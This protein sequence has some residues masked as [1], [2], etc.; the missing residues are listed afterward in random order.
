MM[1]KR[2][3]SLSGAAAL[4][5]L[6]SACCAPAAMAAQAETAL[7][8]ESAVSEDTTREDDVLRI[9]Q[10]GMFS[11]GG[12]VT[13]PV[14]G[15]YDET[16]N[17]QDPTRAGNTMHVDHA[18]VFYQIPENDNGNPIVFLHGAGQSRM[19]WMTT[20]DGREGWS[21][22]FLK[23]WHSVFLVDQPRRGEAGQTAEGPVD[24]QA[25]DQAWYTLQD[26]A[27]RSGTL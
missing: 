24:T 5:L 8:T 11:A 22:I 6:L 25:G 13:D 1:K 12:T 15:D 2:I 17:W 4:V 10:Q 20:P 9:A 26:W 16:K 21:D 14:P 23:A 27:C 3:R 7:Q 19:G 18:N